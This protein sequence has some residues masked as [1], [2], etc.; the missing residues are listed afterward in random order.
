MGKLPLWEGSEGSD[1]NRG[2]PWAGTRGGLAK[3]G[4]AA[5]K[6]AWWITDGS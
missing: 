1:D 2:G 4:A 5:V 3:T 6:T